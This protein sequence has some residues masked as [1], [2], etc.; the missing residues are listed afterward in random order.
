MEFPMFGGATDKDWEQLG[1]VDP[2]WA[3]ISDETYR[4]RRLTDAQLTTFLKSGEDH[5]DD[6]WRI[7]RRRFGDH[8]APRRVL[9]FGC[10]VGRIA[11]PLARRVE[12]V[13]AVDVADS[14]LSVARELLGRSGVANVQLVKSDATLS[15]IDGPFDLVHSVIVLQHI[16]SRI[17]LT[18]TKRL[19]ELA[20]DTGVVVLHVLYHNP[21]KRSLAV[22]VA[23]RLVAPL[24]D[25][26]RRVPEIQMNPY[27][28]NALFKLIQ[29]AGARHVHAELTNHA[30]HLGA[31]LFFRK[32]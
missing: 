31:M 20:G 16:P 9:D 6:I 17:G 13:V 30:D 21:F 7:C 18:L 3:V 28:L 26:F 11:L 25:R 1:Q 15:A 24:R 29:D 2:Y 10:G 32:G 12:S 23:H 22:R 19:I 5:V 4:G 8:F 27:P 14:M